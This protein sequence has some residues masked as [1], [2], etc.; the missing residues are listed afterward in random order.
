MFKKIIEN[1]K[2]GLADG[3]VKSYVEQK[4]IK[5]ANDLQDF[6]IEKG[7]F[8]L[9]NDGKIIEL[10]DKGINFMEYCKSLL[11][12]DLV[13]KACD[14]EFEDIIDTMPADF[15]L[16]NKESYNEKVALLNDMFNGFKKVPYEE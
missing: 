1:F 8:M 11:N 9:T 5:P 14:M 2:K 6:F 10:T 4:V 3:L 13:D 12:N 16:K 7:I 15:I